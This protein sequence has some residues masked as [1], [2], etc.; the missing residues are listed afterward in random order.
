MW[1]SHNMMA[2]G[3]TWLAL[4]AFDGCAVVRAQQPTESAETTGEEET[5]FSL[6]EPSYL[7]SSEELF[8]DTELLWPGFLTGMR[9]TTDF[10]KRFA[11]PVGN[12]FYFESPFV[13]SQFTIH[14]MWHD[15]ASD[16][17]LA[18][19]ELSAF[20]S[21]VRLAL[22]DRL[23]LIV[24]KGGFTL[25]QTGITPEADGWNDFLFG[26]KYAFL[27]DEANDFALAG[28][29]RWELRNGDRDVLQGGDA[30]ANEL[31]PFISVAKGWDRLHFIGAVNYRAPM[32]RN[33]G[34]HI[35][36]WDLHFDYE[37]APETLP[38]FFPLFEIHALHYL[39]DAGAMPLIVGGL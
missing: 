7:L 8:G 15:F 28:G 33:D 2:F 9:A 34:N 31:N 16:S 1:N 29:L 26:L 32:D 19:G 3:T 24:T 17:Q 5:S 21:Q 38:G 13:E 11:E 4:A 22:T 30:G 10:H 18:G 25:F 23:A 20:A 6:G 14:Y 36:Q 39:S 27:V 12:P 35:L 37:I